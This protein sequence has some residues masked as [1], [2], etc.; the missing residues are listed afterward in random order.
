MT[1][2][3]SSIRIRYVWFATLIVDLGAIVL[4]GVL[5]AADAIPSE[6]AIFVVRL[7]VLASV[8]L[9]AIGHKKG[10]VWKRGR[11]VRQ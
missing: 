11:I 8:V 7:L 9:A 2:T 4:L 6:P 3:T 5:D 10:Y 1:K